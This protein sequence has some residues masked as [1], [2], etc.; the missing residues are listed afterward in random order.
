MKIGIEGARLIDREPHPYVTRTDTAVVKVNHADR[1]ARRRQGKSESLDAIGT[2]RA[3]QSVAPAGRSK[4]RDGTVEAVRT[5]IVARRWAHQDRTA[6]VDQI[7]AL[8]A[9]APDDLRGPLA[10]HGTI[11]LVTEAAGAPTLEAVTPS[12]LRLV[13]RSGSSAGV[14]DLADGMDRLDHVIAPC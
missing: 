6:A 13:S 3:A 14:R 1:P 8:V 2:A 5:L 10:R 9:A 7:R 11:E 12:G 4:G